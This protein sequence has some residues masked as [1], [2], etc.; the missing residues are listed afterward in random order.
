MSACPKGFKISPFMQDLM[1]YA[2]QDAPYEQAAA[3]LNKLLGADASAKQI[4][5]LVRAYGP[6]VG[7][8]IMEHED[9]LLP[10]A[11]DA[12]RAYGYLDGCLLLTRTQGWMEVK[13]C[14]VHF[15][16]DLLSL[17]PKRNCVR[18]SEFWGHLGGKDG[19]FELIEPRIGLLSNLVVV[20]DG[21]AW[22]WKW[23][24]ENFP[25]AIQILDSFHAFEYLTPYAKEQFRDQTKAKEWV[26]EQ[27]E[28]LKADEV[29]QVIDNI[30]TAFPPT[31][32]AKEQQKRISTYFTNNKGRMKYKTYTDQGLQIGSG[33]IESANR[34]AIQ[35]RLKRSGQRWT[36]PGAQA[37]INIRTAQLSG[38]W[39][40]VLQ[41]IRKTA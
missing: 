21:A 7:E 36:I 27:K 12:E 30:R 18:K 17:S 29:E 5:R 6:L 32:A 8:A 26:E 41:E 39:N 31:K 35:H 16:E 9:S 1:L 15:E 13:L 11:A 33:P 23:V 14:R 24:G 40:F 2:G 22:I 25:N 4:E 19:F 37:V 3:S 34:T 38:K 10:C 28:L 20:S